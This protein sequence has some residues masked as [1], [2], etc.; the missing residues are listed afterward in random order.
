[1]LEEKL[2]PIILTVAVV[3]AAFILLFI[4]PIGLWISAHPAVVIA[5]IAI[6]VSMIAW[7]TDNTQYVKGGLVIALA[8]ILF[9]YFT[10]PYTVC[11]FAPAGL[12]QAAIQQAGTSALSVDTLICKSFVGAFGNI[13]LFSAQAD[14]NFLGFLFPLM[15]MIIVITLVLAIKVD[16]AF[17][18]AV[19][20]SIILTAVVVLVSQGQTYQGTF[21]LTVATIVTYLIAPVFLFVLFA[22]LTRGSDSGSELTNE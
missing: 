17:W 20:Y 8:G 9:D 5:L 10:P 16:K 12:E 22:M 14:G 7:K 21:A 18:T 13:T 19:V 11:A 2:M 1:M 4:P 6:V 15:I 3:A